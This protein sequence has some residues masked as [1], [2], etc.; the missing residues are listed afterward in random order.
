MDKFLDHFR[1][2]LVGGAV[3]VLPLLLVIF[4]IKKAVDLLDPLTDVV[5]ARLGVGTLIGAATTSVFSLLTLIVTA[6]LFGLFARTLVGQSFVKWMQAGILSALPRF[7]LVQGLARSIDEGQG[8]EV[9]VVLI[10]TDAGWCLG[11]QL[12]ERHGDWCTVYI[13]G[14]PQWTSGSLS[15]AHIDDVHKVDVPLGRILFLMRRCGMGATD[16]CDIL[17]ELKAKGTI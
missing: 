3:F 7:N 5:V 12:E 13:P 17:A 1:T 14:S 9:P 8:K 11:L 15:F 6:F 2:T 4:I 10:P 16:V